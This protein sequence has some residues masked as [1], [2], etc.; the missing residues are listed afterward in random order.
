MSSLADTSVRCFIQNTFPCSSEEIIQLPHVSIH[1]PTMNAINAS[2]E[3]L[4]KQALIANIASAHNDSHESHWLDIVPAPLRQRE[5]DLVNYL[6]MVV[7]IDFRH[8]AEK[9]DKDGHLADI[10]EEVSG[11]SGFYCVA[12]TSVLSEADTKHAEQKNSAGEGA[13]PDDSKSTR[14]V[15]GS[16]AMM[17]LLRRAVEE[18][19]IPWYDPIYLSGL[20]NEDEALRVLEPCFIGCEEDGVHPMWMPAVKERISLLL[21]LGNELRRLN[22]SFYEILVSSQGYLFSSQVDSRTG[23]VDQLRLLHSRYDDI[24]SLQLHKMDS[25]CTIPILKLSQLTA[26]GIIDALKAFWLRKVE[27]ANTMSSS[28]PTWLQRRCEYYIR[29]RAGEFFHVFEDEQKLSLCCDYQIPKALRE[30]QILVYDRDLSD[31]IDRHV[32]IAPGSCEEVAIRVGTL[33]AGEML[34]DFLNENRY[35]LCKRFNINHQNAQ[36][37]PQETKVTA[38]DPIITSNALDYSLWYM[39]RTLSAKHHLCR[40]TMY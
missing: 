3:L 31:R 26:V 18:H 28:K 13:T 29:M 7:A 25:I 30:S 11:F 22:T 36:Q 5:E 4:I 40:T 1:R 10:G 6:G 15:R 8:W 24:G 38:K 14:T 20:T 2:L 32:L 19:R 23:F 39:G 9:P 12:S 27:S 21:S 34:L 33:V 16:A 37:S 17:F 35:E